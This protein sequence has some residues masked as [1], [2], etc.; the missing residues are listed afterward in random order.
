MTGRFLP[1]E[2]SAARTVELLDPAGLAVATHDLLLDDTFE[3]TA[4][5]KAPGLIEYRLRVLDDE[6]ELHSEPVPAYVHSGRRPLIFIMQSAPSFET[7]QL[8]NWA[9]DDAATVIVHTVI[10]RGRELGQRVNAGTLGDDSLSPSLLQKT[11]LAVVDGRTWAGLNPA[12]RAMFE[13]AVKDGLGLLILADDDLA[14]Y[15][16]GSTVLLQGFELSERERDQDGYIPVVSGSTSEQPLPLLNLEL[17]H[18]GNG[19]LTRV[20]TG[21]VV[22]AYERIGL[23]RVA[24]SI[25]RERHRWL[26]SG[27]PTCCRWKAARCRR[28]TGARTSARWRGIVRY[29]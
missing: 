22:E 15:L 21:V 3:L 6:N 11:D 14:E 12:Q 2:S 9:G 17:E 10:T 20:E 8:K 7:R 25:L 23:G 5:P 16:R 18:R 19:V 4:L 26:T 29:R 24:V 27:C 13:A 1:D 28:R